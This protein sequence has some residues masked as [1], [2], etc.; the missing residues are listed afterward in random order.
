MFYM[1]VKVGSKRNR[2]NGIKGNGVV[3]IMKVFDWF[4]MYFFKCFGCEL[5]VKIILMFK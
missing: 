1:I 2:I 5:R 4:V 3:D